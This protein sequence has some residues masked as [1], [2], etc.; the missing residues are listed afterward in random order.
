[1]RRED[2]ELK[3]MYS[4]LGSFKKWFL[5]E[6]ARYVQEYMSQ[7]LTGRPERPSIHLNYEI[8]RREE[9]PDQFQ[10]VADALLSGYTNN[11]T[12]WYNASLDEVVEQTER[13]LALWYKQEWRRLHLDFRSVPLPTKIEIKQQDRE[14]WQVGSLTVSIQG[15]GKDKSIRIRTTDLQLIDSFSYSAGL[16][17]KGCAE[18]FQQVKGRAMRY[19]TLTDWDRLGELSDKARSALIKRLEIIRD[20]YHNKFTYAWKLDSFKWDDLKEKG[21]NPGR[22]DYYRFEKFFLTKKSRAA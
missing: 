12:Q 3:A 11:L 8:L 2:A 19:A 13:E 14:T 9:L 15:R 7:D 6:L 10:P 21:Y 1:M 4:K 16:G 5:E 17:Y 22:A 18:A 20:Y